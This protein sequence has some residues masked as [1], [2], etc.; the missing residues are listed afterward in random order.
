MEKIESKEHCIEK[1]VEGKTISQLY[2]TVPFDQVIFLESSN[3]N[4]SKTRSNSGSGW[5]HSSSKFVSSSHDF[6]LKAGEACQEECPVDCFTRTLY[7]TL[8]ESSMDSPT[9]TVSTRFEEPETI[10]RYTPKFDFQAYIIY[11]AG[12]FSIWFSASIFHSVTDIYF[13]CRKFLMYMKD[14]M[15]RRERVRRSERRRRPRGSSGMT[16]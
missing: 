9:L 16:R 12:V 4:S 5:Q 6:V 2:N 7:T 8:S 3:E 10:V 15:V 11:E 14:I 1:C 13:F